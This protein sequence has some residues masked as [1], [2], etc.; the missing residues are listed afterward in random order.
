MNLYE[1]LNKLNIK[2]EEVKH[3]AVYT[4]E[5]AQNIKCNIDGVGC[6]NLFLK[7]KNNNYY[8]VIIR[9]DK[10]ADI[11]KLTKILNVKKLSFATEKELKEILNLQIGSC[12]PFGIIND[13]ENK[14]IL[15]IDKELQNKK[16]L[17]HPNINTATISINY[18]DLIKF[19]DY[20]Q[21]K[22]ILI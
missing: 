5:E 11:K 10:R 12:T 16:L 1:I 18:S 15:L 2:Y 9:E 7:A 22:Y 3:E 14:V 20:E 8:L 21:H 4:I 6:K 13:L 17:F 19:I